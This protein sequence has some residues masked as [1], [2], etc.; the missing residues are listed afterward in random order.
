MN[1]CD[2]LADISD[3]SESPGFY[4]TQSHEEGI[5]GIGETTI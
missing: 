3:E 2:H 1:S 5:R 4:A